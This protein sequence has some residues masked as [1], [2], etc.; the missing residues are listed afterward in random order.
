MPQAA[1]VTIVV[2]PARSGSSAFRDR[3]EPRADLFRV[4]AELLEPWQLGQAA[5][6]EDPLEERRRAIADGPTRAGLSAGLA[7]EAA[8]DQARDGRVRGDAP[9]ARDVRPRARAEV[10]DDRQRLERGL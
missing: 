5:E 6:P 4:A 7:E 9:D 10:G 3:V 8:L 2:L 1:P